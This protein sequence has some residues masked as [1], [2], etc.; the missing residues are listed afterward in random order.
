MFSGK[1]V[2]S[3]ILFKNYDNIFPAS[4][5]DWFTWLG[6]V[7]EVGL[8]GDQTFVIEDTPEERLQ[9]ILFKVIRKEVP[10]FNSFED[11]E[12]S[13]QEKIFKGYGCDRKNGTGHGNCQKG[14]EGFR[15]SLNESLLDIEK[16]LKSWLDNELSSMQKKKKG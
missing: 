12:V 6:D 9:D 15:F 4:E 2:E 3:C 11:A 8:I 7:S 16:E 10:S 1:E 14:C 13:L 5:A